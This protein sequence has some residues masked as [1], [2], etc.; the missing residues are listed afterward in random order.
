MK[1]LFLGSY[2]GLF[3]DLHQG[4]KELGHEPFI[5]H[6]GSNWQNH[7]A[8]LVFDNS[9]KGV[10]KI[11]KVLEEYRFC[12]SLHKFDK[13][14]LQNPFLFSRQ[15]YINDILIN[16]VL[17]SNEN[18]YLSAAGTDSFS[19]LSYHQLKYHPYQDLIDNNDD[20]N[21]YKSSKAYKWN[22][23]LASKVKK[24][25]PISIEYTL[26]YQ[27]F[28]N[29]HATIPIPV[30]LSKYDFHGN[31]AKDKI[32][33][34]H[35]VTRKGFKGTNYISKA[36]E[37][38]T[39]KY[40]NDFEFIMAGNMPIDEYKK[41]LKRS[42]I[43]VDQCNS[44]GYGVNAA[45]SL[46]LGKIV[47]SGSEPEAIKELNADSCPIFNITPNVQQIE[48]T[49]LKVLDLKSSF[50]DLGIQ[51]REY[52]KKYHDHMTITKKYLDALS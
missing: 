47:L 5:V 41:A 15:F 11:F 40:P 13:V 30:N 25:I 19:W 45:I 51:G 2:S 10:K 16:R 14:I 42:H 35:G 3:T 7:G 12:S 44:H 38:L 9:E 43:I 50:D 8:D 28:N 26:G 1:I 21:F 34:F 31:M 27:Q 29:L 36:F 39:Q 17:R 49:L 18:C 52:I 33:V 4:L 46:A 20:H 48:D 32:V 22:K 6:I 24:I 23:S 37:N